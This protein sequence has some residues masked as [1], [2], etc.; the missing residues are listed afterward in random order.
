[1]AG[2]GPE[3][4][5]PLLARLPGALAPTR[6]DRASRLK[7]APSWP[8]SVRGSASAARYGLCTAPLAGGRLYGDLDRGRGHPGGAGAASSLIQP[9]AGQP[10]HEQRRAEHDDL[11]ISCRCLIVAWT[12]ARGRPVMSSVLPCWR[13]GPGKSRGCPGQPRSACRDAGRRSDIISRARVRH[14]KLPGVVADDPRGGQSSRCRCRC[15]GSPGSGAA[16]S[17]AVPDPASRDPGQRRRGRGERARRRVH[18]PGRRSR[19]RSAA[20]RGGRAGTASAPPR[21]PRATP[22]LARA[23]EAR[24]AR[25]SAGRAGVRPANQLAAARSARRLEDIADAA[26]GAWI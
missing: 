12:P 18:W 24:A 15:P 16:C 21:S 19:R 13:P 1:M 14:A 22:M 25:R 6:H 2:V 7:A 8:T 23:E 20:G 5:Q 10:D 17:A 26:D 4:A 11:R 9:V 3:P